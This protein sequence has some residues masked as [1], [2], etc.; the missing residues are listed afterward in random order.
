MKITLTGILVFIALVVG[1]FRLYAV[2]KGGL[3]RLRGRPGPT[4]FDGL[5]GTL[6]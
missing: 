3:N 4:R 2:L 1:F 5:R 6:W